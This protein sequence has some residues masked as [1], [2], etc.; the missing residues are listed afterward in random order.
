MSLSTMHI[1]TLTLQKRIPVSIENVRGC[2][3]R[4]VTTF[5]QKHDNAKEKFKSHFSYQ[6]SFVDILKLLRWSLAYSS[7]EKGSQNV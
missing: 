3:H 5:P 1:D 7:I 6:Y 2:D 4:P